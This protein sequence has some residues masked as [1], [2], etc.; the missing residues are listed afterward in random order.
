M[1]IFFAKYAGVCS[2]GCP[3]VIGTRISIGEGGVAICSICTNKNYH[4]MKKFQEEQI[5][6]EQI[7][8][9]QTKEKTKEKK[10]G[11]KE[12]ETPDIA[13]KM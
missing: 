8:R 9:E 10:E 11:D 2:C 5:Q 13:Q 4:E 6:R 1:N 12:N 7:Q 3:I